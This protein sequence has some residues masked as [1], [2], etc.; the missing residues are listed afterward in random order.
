MKAFICYGDS[1]TYG[2]DPRS[3]VGDRFPKEIRWT[4]I[5]EKSLGVPVQEHGINGRCIP[6]TG[7]A[8]AFFKEQIDRWSHL[9]DAY[10]LLMLGTN[11]FLQNPKA[12]AEEVAGRMGEFLSEVL[13]L[14]GS[15]R[16]ILV[17]PPR[18]QRGAWVEEDSMCI[19]S[20]RLGDCYRELA[21]VFNIP[22]I[23]MS[24]VE[25]PLL[26]DG[27]HMSEE[28]HRIFAE[29]IAGE[30]MRGELGK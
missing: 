30:L 23:D 19:E 12:L 10:L 24:K 25:I 11:D 3:F 9:E 27:V 14:A 6:H 15:L 29:Y 8:V 28:G 4:K 2:Y 17:T 26:Y 5:L 20:G 1:N 7:N 21:E 16:V 18:M 22:C 13:P